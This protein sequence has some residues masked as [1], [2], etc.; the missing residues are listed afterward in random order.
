MFCALAH[1]LQVYVED[2][3]A[4]GTWINQSTK[5]ARGQ[6][7]LLHSGDEI[8]LLNP[9]KHN[10]RAVGMASHRVKDRF[11]R[12]RDEADKLQVEEVTFTFINLNRR[13]SERGGLNGR[14][15]LSTAMLFIVLEVS[16]AE[17]DGHEW[18]DIC[19]IFVF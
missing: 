16:S 10:N 4:N 12:G 3:S 6:R 5:L 14:R 1:G 15:T 18:E 11:G 2:M 9:Y 7:R 13:V 17:F 8:A 19:G